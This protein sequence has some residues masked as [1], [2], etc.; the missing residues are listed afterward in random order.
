[1]QRVVFEY[2]SSLDRVIIRLRTPLIDR[3]L[4]A[5]ALGA[6]TGVYGAFRE[7]TR[8]HTGYESSAEFWIAAAVSVTVYALVAGE[9]E[10]V[11][12]RDD[13]VQID[14][15]EKS[16]L[17]DRG[18]QS[19]PS[20]YRD[21]GRMWFGYP[22]RGVSFGR[23][24]TQAEADAVL[25]A[26]EVQFGRGSD[27]TPGHRRSW[28][29]LVVRY[30]PEVAVI[31]FAVVAA[32]VGSPQWFVVAG[33]ILLVMLGQVALVAWNRRHPDPVDIEQGDGFA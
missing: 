11:T 9:D 17:I 33:L 21:E 10:V 13:T 25:R 18:Q 29:A 5:F 3:I 16:I 4:W 2:P 26:F 12:V 23:K 7:L 15:I 31:A 24:L 27:A 6:I 1:M 22:S 28:R 8:A 32:L 19:T 14:T 30:G 20:F